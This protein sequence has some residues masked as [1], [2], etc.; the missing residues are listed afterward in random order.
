MFNYFFLSFI[1]G[2]ISF[3]ALLH[4]LLQIYWCSHYCMF[5]CLGHY[6]SKRPYDLH[7]YF[8]RCLLKSH[9][10]REVFA[11]QTLWS[12]VPQHSNSFSMLYVF[13]WHFSLTSFNILVCSFI[14]VYL[15]GTCKFHENEE[16]VLFSDC[17]KGPEQ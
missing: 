5:P 16:F 8:L 7:S 10:L 2:L 1:S 12:R 14:F 13:L 6:S 4:T 17:L 15:F 11:D 9:F 3:H